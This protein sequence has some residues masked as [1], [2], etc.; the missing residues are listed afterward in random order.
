[1]AVAGGP[2]AGGA[3]R[4]GVRRPRGREG[5]RGTGAGTPAGAH[6][7]R[8]GA[9]HHTGGGRRP[10]AGR[11]AR[12]GDHRERRCPAAVTSPRWYIGLESL[13]LAVIGVLALA[14]GALVSRPD[15]A[16]IGSVFVLTFAWGWITR[17][18]AQPG[19]V[20]RRTSARA[21]AGA[22]AA[23]VHVPTADGVETV[24]LRVSS[25]GFRPVEGLVDARP[26]RVLPTE[27][28]T[29]RTGLQDMSRLDHLSASPDSAVLSPLET[30]GPLRLTVHPPLVTLQGTP[31]PPRLAGLTGNHTSRRVGD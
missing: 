4:A 23:E 31:V 10:A 11:G 13:A 12:P 25:A 19:V 7:G 30:P 20:V 5:H 29:A 16:L 24:R 27:L 1:G 22:V 17:P 3:G 14:V 8:V 6:P 2:G 9:G 21:R 18:T 26:E 28:A 15:V